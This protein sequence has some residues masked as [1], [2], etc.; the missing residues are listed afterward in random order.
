[1][2]RIGEAVD[3][4]D[5][6]AAVVVLGARHEILDELPV[7]AVDDADE[8]DPRQRMGEELGVQRGAVAILAAVVELGEVG[9]DRLRDVAG[10]AQVERVRQRP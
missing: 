10:N 2:Q 7:D 9:G 6:A 5:L 8:L 1:M 3:D 4:A